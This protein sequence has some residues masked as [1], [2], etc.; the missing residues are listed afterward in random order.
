M[1]TDFFIRFLIPCSCR[2]PVSASPPL[3]LLLVRLLPMMEETGNSSMEEYLC[4]SALHIDPSEAS[5]VVDTLINKSY[6]NEGLDMALNY[7]DQTLNLSRMFEFPQVTLDVT[8]ER[9]ETIHTSDSL[10]I[11]L[12]MILLFLTIMTVWAFKAFRFRI[13]HETGLALLYGMLRT[14][15]IISFISYTCTC[16][17]R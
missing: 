13:F 9:T 10:A 12:I 1:S 17:A 14:L 3:S 16:T 6:T 8:D 7:L 2:I 11:L 5:Q 4:Y 15:Y